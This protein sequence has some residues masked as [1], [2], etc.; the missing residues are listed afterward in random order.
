MVGEKT[1]LEPSLLVYTFI[2]PELVFDFYHALAPHSLIEHYFP[3]FF[4]S[5]AP[6]EINQTSLMT[7]YLVATY[8][9]KETKR[10]VFVVERVEH[11]VYSWKSG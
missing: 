5:L 1:R 6:Y 3:S 2:F 11:S 4:F 7:L 10:N 9:Q 8:Y